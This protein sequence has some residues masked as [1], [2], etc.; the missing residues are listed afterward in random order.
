MDERKN[1]D[2]SKCKQKRIIENSEHAA[3]HRMPDA[4]HT[5]LL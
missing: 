3:F 5:P 2:Q 4:H 1:T